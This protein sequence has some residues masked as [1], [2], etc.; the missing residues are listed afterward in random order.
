MNYSRKLFWDLFNS[1]TCPIS[2]VFFCA[3]THYSLN[4]SLVSPSSQT[5]LYMS[6]LCLTY[7]PRCFYTLLPSFLLRPDY[8]LAHLLSVKFDC[9]F[10]LFS[11]SSFVNYSPELHS[12]LVNLVNESF[13]WLPRNEFLYIPLFI[14]ILYVFI[15]L[16]QLYVANP[17]APLFCCSCF[18]RPFNSIIILP[19]S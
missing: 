11:I 10:V 9:S 4:R 2:T 1:I 6:S 13:V 7:S 3:R 16:A 12:D 14:L 15:F 18:H 17:S 19:T 8:L 5:V